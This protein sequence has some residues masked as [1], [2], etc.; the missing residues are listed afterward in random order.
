MDDN[1]KIA[2]EKVVQEHL[3]TER[4][5][6][7]AERSWG[8]TV[9]VWAAASAAVCAAVFFAVTTVIAIKY[10]VPALK[11]S[12]ASSQA[13]AEGLPVVVA[14]FGRTINDLNNEKN[15]LPAMLVAGRDDLIQLKATMR[16]QNGNL[17]RVGA[18]A[19]GAVGQVQSTTKQMGD[20]LDTIVA[21][22]DTVSTGPDGLV[23]AATALLNKGK[24]TMGDVDKAAMEMLQEG[25]TTE[26]TFN[27][28][29][30]NAN[31][32]KVLDALAR[33]VNNVADLAAAL[34]MDAKDLDG[35]IQNFGE[36]LDDFDKYSKTA[37][38]WHKWVLLA[39]IINLLGG[40][41]RP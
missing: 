3:Q 27:G 10:G 18:S 31:V 1:Q 14:G 11:A 22:L 2:D 32:P 9:L 33:G 26:R 7:V 29:I 4:A 39:Q 23:P 34:D 28:I 41:P 17:L 15:G 36:L 24:L 25:L 6:A 35:A 37:N 20:R 38:K 30:G 5:R 12:I 21:H 16:D 19:S 8:Y 40:L 13:T